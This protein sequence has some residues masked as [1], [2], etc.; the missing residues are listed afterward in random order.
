[1]RFSHWKK[2]LNKGHKQKVPL[3]LLSAVPVWIG[4]EHSPSAVGILA[5][6]DEAVTAAP[7][8]WPGWD[9]LGVFAAIAVLFLGVAGFAKAAGHW[10]SAIPINVYEQLLPNAD[11]ATHPMLE[12]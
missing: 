4:Q 10:D 3:L 7:K 8:S 9:D 12:R 11:Q 1:M 5:D 6:P 2:S